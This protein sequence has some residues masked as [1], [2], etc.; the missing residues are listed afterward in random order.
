MNKLHFHLTLN[1]GS[2]R[3]PVHL[4]LPGKGIAVLFGASGSGKTSLLRAIA[5][6]DRHADARIQINE[7]LW[8]DQ[9]NFV[10]VHHRQLGY[11]FQDDNLFQHLSCAGNLHFAAKRSH[12]PAAFLSRVIDQLGLSALMPRMPLHLS[13]GEKQKVAIARALVQKPRLLMLDEPFSAVDEEFK[14]AFLPALKTL[15]NEL[16]LPALYVTHSSAEMSQMAD[17]LIYFRPGNSPVVAPTNELLTDLHQGLAFRSEAESF[18]E[19][20]VSGHDRDYG[21]NILE[22]DGCTLFTGGEFLQ[23]G[24]QVRVRIMAQD[25]SLALSPPTMSSILNI[26]PVTVMELSEL[27]GHQT[28]IRLRAG[29][30]TILARI[31]RKSAVV[32]QLV[33]GMQLYAQI[34]SV[35]VLH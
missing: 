16:D 14:H 12:T 24:Q 23:I 10:A 19:V 18:L 3:L 20:R 1:R 33:K 8:Q 5:G 32:L 28:T 2:F 7:T 26:L 17:T 30:Q 9:Q 22:Y 15:L 31:T 25:V 11:V 4:E 29:N 27:A 21:L 34:K 35:A 6:L 13:G